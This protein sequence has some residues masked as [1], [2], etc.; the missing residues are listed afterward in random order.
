[1][2]PAARQLD[3]QSRIL[4]YCRELTEHQASTVRAYGGI[5][6]H[7][8]CFQALW[9]DGQFDWSRL[10]SQELVAAWVK[11]QCRK[12]DHTNAGSRLGTLRNF[13]EY[14]RTEKLLN[15]NAADELLA[16]Y[17]RRG[18][19]GLAFALGSDAPQQALGEL[20]AVSRFSGPWGSRMAEFVQLKH[21]LGVGYSF[22]ERTLAQLDRY[23]ASAGLE[24]E[25]SPDQ[26]RCWLDGLP[27]I[28]AKTRDTKRRVAEQFF[29]QAIRRGYTTCNPARSLGKVARMRKQPFVF[30]IEQIQ[31]VQDEAAALPDIPFFAY[32][33]AT[34]AV[35]FATMYCLGLRVG[36]TCRLLRGDVDLARGI[37]LIRRSK[38]Y[39]SRLLPVGSKYLSYLSK[40]L[41]LRGGMHD[42][43]DAPLFPSRYGH[44]IG[45]TAVGTVF[46]QIAAKIGLA[47]KAGQR[48]ACLHSFRHSFALHRLI[49]WYHEGADVQAKLPLLS[50]FMGHIDIA[51]TQA[52]LEATPELLDAAN[53]RFE[54]RFGRPRQARG[55]Q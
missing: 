28:D 35:I 23:L 25:V 49:R 39:K 6:N 14:L 15:S 54:A 19:K 51:S 44:P 33:G 50:A 27:G 16:S 11:S 32:R 2:S 18:F 53:E 55:E 36:E 26:I 40:F 17:P 45:R 48:G 20:Q 30:N 5:L 37:I 46:R 21:S 9:S 4:A 13:L 1:M 43:A 8:N 42:H 22:E 24:T 41:V 47:P 38:F 3:L 52:Y 12:V 7:F 29:D 34:Y 10:E 31:Q